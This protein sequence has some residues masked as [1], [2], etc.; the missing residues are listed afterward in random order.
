MPSDDNFSYDFDPAS[1]YSLTTTK[2]QAKGTAKPP[3]E[4]PFPIP[5]SENFEKPAL[6]K[7]ATYLSDQDGAFEVRPCHYR[8][9]R[10][11]QQV[12]LAKPIPWDALPDPWTLAGDE[13]WSDYQ[14][15]VDVLVSETGPVTLMGRIDS[16][17]LFHDSGAHYPS[18]YVFL[19]NPNGQW[20]LFSKR[21]TAARKVLA[22]GK[23]QFAT[24]KW[25]SMELRFRG[26]Q[27]TALLDGQ[28]LALVIDHSHTEGMIGM[29]TGWNSAQ[30]D[31]LSIS[32]N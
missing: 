10:C 21:Y 9:G 16:A 4:K 3:P 31:N 20:K 13:S 8:L 1:L 15:A 22:S 12:V 7:A 18:G 17:N 32:R 11:L 28:Q 6:T 27:I 29:G 2:G 5:Y 24:I 30:F 19:L 23:V 14:V 25:H 26:A